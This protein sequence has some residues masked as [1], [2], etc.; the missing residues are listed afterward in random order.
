MDRD[1]ARA[2]AQALFD[3]W[4]ES[5]EDRLASLTALSATD[6]TAIEQAGSL[7]P[8]E[9]GE[10]L[11]EI[12]THAPEKTLQ[13]AARRGLHRLRAAGRATPAPERTST[14][15]PVFARV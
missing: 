6:V 9:V 12:A 1:E 11:S 3:S 4:R 8:P 5:G 10:F 7:E 14:A 13:K 2:R 15:T